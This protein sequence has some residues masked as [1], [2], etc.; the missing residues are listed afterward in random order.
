MEWQIWQ[1]INNVKMLSRTLNKTDTQLSIISGVLDWDSAVFAPM[2]MSCAPPMW[3]WAW[4]DDEDEDERTANDKPPTSEGV[5]LK[6]AFE[7]AAGKDFAKFAYEP[8]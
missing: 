4:Q 1:N 6:L 5:R 2:F 8:A 7:E 3:I